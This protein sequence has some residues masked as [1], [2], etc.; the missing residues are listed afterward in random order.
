MDYIGAEVTLADLP[1]GINIQGSEKEGNG[2]LP[3]SIVKEVRY[4]YSTDA[5]ALQKSLC[6]SQRFG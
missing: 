2:V 4:D 6:M 3:T 1:K 5:K